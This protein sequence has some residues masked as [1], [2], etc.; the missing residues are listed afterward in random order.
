MTMAARRQLVAP[1]WAGFLLIITGCLSFVGSY[2]LL[3][4]VEISCFDTCDVPY[5][6]ATAWEMSLLS[7]PALSYPGFLVGAAVALALCYL[8]LLAAVMVVGCSIGF[9]LHPQ[10]TFANWS[11]RAWL[12]GIIALVIA[13]AFLSFFILHPYIGYG[14]M[15]FGYGLFWA[16]NRLFL[17]AHP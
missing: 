5:T 14:G 17:T 12:V 3:P 6:Y 4:V 11:H 9:L 1:A 8:P 13:L 2:F 15:L 16:G 7:L 10:R